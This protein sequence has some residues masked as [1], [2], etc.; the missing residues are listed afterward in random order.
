MTPKQRAKTFAARHGY[1]L[2]QLPHSAANPMP[3]VRVTS[4]DGTQAVVSDWSAATEWMLER[5]YKKK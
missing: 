3:S 1:T 2:R 4:P 5:V